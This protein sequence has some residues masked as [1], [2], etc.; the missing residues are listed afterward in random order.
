MS[1]IASGYELNDGRRIPRMGFGTFGLERGDEAKRAV[2]GAL[3]AGYC[4]IDCARLYGNERSVGEALRESG[5]A[6][7]EVFVTS[8]VW[9]DRQM[10][11]SDEIRRSVEETLTALQLDQL[12]LLLVH[13]PVR[14]KYRYTWEQFQLF[15]EE[16]LVASIGVS[17]FQRVHLDDLLSGGDEVPVVDQMEL[18]PYLQDA[19]TLDACA[20]RNIVVEAWSPL[21]RGLCVNDDTVLDI[22]R[23]HGADAGQVIL[24][25]EASKGILPLPRSSKPERI[26]GNLKALDLVLSADEIAAV[27]ALNRNQYSIEGVDP[28]HF[29]ETLAGVVSPRD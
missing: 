9:N 23:V 1:D 28:V 11:G 25:W 29:N 17:N 5:L 22:A 4:L 13:W 10:A 19:D 15:K 27:D 16:G 24:A 7:N 12:D 14:G 2:L 8:K 6:R 3:E 20:K 18:H 21:G 26:A